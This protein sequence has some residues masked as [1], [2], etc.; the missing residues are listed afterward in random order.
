LDINN[1]NF[2]LCLTFKTLYDWVVWGV[3]TILSGL[4]GQ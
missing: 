2:S 3:L 4:S 1:A